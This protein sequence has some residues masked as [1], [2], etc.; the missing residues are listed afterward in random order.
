[1]DKQQFLQAAFHLY[2]NKY[3]YENA[4]IG[5]KKDKIDVNCPKHGTFHPTLKNFLRGHA[6][7]LCGRESRAEKRKMST[8][9]FIRRSRAI[10]GDKYDYSKVKYTGSHNKVTII[11]PI[12]GEF[13]QIAWTHLCGCGCKKCGDEKHGREARLTKEE[14]VEKAE[15]RWG[16][17]YDYSKADYQGN[18]RKVEIRCKKHDF[19]FWQTP[20]NHLSFEGCPICAINGQIGRMY[21]KDSYSERIHAKE[22]SA[23]YSHWRAMLTRCTNE[24]YKEK[25][26]TY[27]DVAI[28]K[29]WLVFANFAKWFEEN[30]HKGCDLDKDLLS[31]KENKKYSPSTCCFIPHAINVVITFKTRKKGLPEGVIKIGDR[32][33]AR[34]SSHIGER[35]EIGT[36]ETADEAHAAYIK[37]KNRIV[38]QLAEDYFSKGKISYTVYKALKNYDR[39]T[40]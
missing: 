10:F 1:M 34:V 6:C 9:E 26:P 7:P 15:K 23:A 14:W 3:S 21:D 29:E 16:E 17:K 28:C 20:S 13:E 27:K 39:E 33:V 25:H 24:T 35:Y 12:H 11:C 2:G 5:L 36:F 8:D 18:T 38:H 31:S 40:A 37:E 32:Y 30:Y 22:A 19:T 4:V